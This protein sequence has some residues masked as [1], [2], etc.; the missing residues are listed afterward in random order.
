[1]ICFAALNQFESEIGNT[2]D[3][4]S[5]AYRCTEQYKVAEFQFPNECDA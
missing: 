3:R 1:M 5:G 4:Q 2:E